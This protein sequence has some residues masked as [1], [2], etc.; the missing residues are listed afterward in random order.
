MGGLRKPLPGQGPPSAP[1]PPMG[2]GSSQAT[3]GRTGLWALAG[4]APPVGCARL[5]PTAARHPLSGAVSWGL[6]TPAAH[7]QGEGGRWGGPPGAWLV[8]G[9]LPRVPPTAPGRRALSWKPRSRT[10][11]PATH[12]SAPG[13]PCWTREEARPSGAVPRLGDSAGTPSVSRAAARLHLR[14]TP[15]AGTAGHA[16]RRTGRS[17]RRPAGDRGAGLGRP[18]GLSQPPFLLYMTKGFYSLL[19]SL[20]GLRLSV[21]REDFV[22]DET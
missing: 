19:M 4:G 3:L 14:Q 9:L 5:L 20:P 12:P 2:E 21:L 6:G 16:L 11:P 15:R 10:A 8:P 7:V 22:N 17:H 1:R 13:F 18:A